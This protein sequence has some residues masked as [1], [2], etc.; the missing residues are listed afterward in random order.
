MHTLLTRIRSFL[1]VVT[2]IG[3]LIVM[4][5]LFLPILLLPRSVLVAVST[6]V[7]SPECQQW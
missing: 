6:D 7:T 4:M 1:F 5:I 2:Y 3:M